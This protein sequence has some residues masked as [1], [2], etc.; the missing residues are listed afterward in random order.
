MY[1]KAL[2]LAESIRQEVAIYKF[3]SIELNFLIS[4]QNDDGSSMETRILLTARPE[5]SK[6][7]FTF[8]ASL[9]VN[10]TA[11]VPG[12]VK[13]KMSLAF[14]SPNILDCLIFKDLTKWTGK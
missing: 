2:A 7:L 10:S 8:T 11:G 9:R 6:M 4:W 12:M 13:S 3:N 14:F 5:G 1:I